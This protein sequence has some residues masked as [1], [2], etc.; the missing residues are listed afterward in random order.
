MARVVPTTTYEAPGVLVTAGVWNNGPKAL[1]DWLINKPMSRML[2]NLNQSVTSGAWTA[3]QLAAT[4]S[5]TDGGHS[6]TVNNT[7]YTCQVAGWYWVK[8][9]AAINPTGAGN[10]ASRID[11]ALAKNG[12]IWVGAS[13]F[14]D[15]GANVNSAQQ[16]SGLVQLAV[17]DYLEIWVRQF[18][19][20]S[21]LLDPN[22]FGTESDLN[23]LW[24][25]Q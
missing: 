3:I 22:T 5:D 18:T 2:G 4:I 12:T 23:L 16:A 24:V 11:T 9:I 25:S 21:V 15:K 6:I 17:G 19:G 14:L 1:N 20:V 7:R 8:G 10:G 13:E